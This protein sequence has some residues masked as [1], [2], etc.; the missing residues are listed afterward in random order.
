MNN[1]VRV[2]KTPLL[3]LAFKSLSSAAISANMGVDEQD[4]ELLLWCIETSLMKH[5]VLE[6]KLDYD[7]KDIFWK[8][9]YELVRKGGSTSNTVR[10]CKKEPKN[11]SKRY[12]RNI[13]PRERDDEEEEERTPDQQLNDLASAIAKRILTPRLEKIEQET[14]ADENDIRI[15]KEKEKENVKKLVERI[16]FDVSE[17]FIKKFV[18]IYFS[19]DCQ[20]KEKNI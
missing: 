9:Y 19:E 7:S 17:E 20:I 14:W 15:M 16:F 4:L 1:A 11:Q 5:D 12:V 10:Y 18:E 8:D 6:V 13:L 2:Y 3:S